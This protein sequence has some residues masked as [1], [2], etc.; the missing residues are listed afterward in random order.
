[1]SARLPIVV[2]VDDSVDDVDLTRRALARTGVGHTLVVA[3]DGVL[4][5]DYLLARGAHAGRPPLAQPALVLLD[6]KLPRL[7]GL[8]VL[9]ALRAEPPTQATPVV[10]LSSSLEAT[11]LATAYRRG[12]NSYLRKPVDFDE[13]TRAMGHVMAYWL[14]L[15]ITPASV[16][17]IR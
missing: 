13:F 11:D 16:L 2:L 12:A 9:T 5:L 3:D 1:M 17:T 6:L 15:N 4:A 7:D 14:E 10:V 8:E